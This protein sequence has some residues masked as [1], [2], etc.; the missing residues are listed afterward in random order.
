MGIYMTDLSYSNVFSQQQACMDYFAAIT[1]LATE[2][3]L[4]DVFTKDFIEK[5]DANLSNEDSILHYL[6]QS[7][8]SANLELKED[9]RESVA[10]L[11]AAGGWMEGL[12]IPTHII[13]P[14]NKNDPITERI[15]EQGATLKQLIKFLSSFK[16][17]KNLL[18]VISDLEELEQLFDKI[19]VES[20]RMETKNGDDGIAVVGKKKVYTFEGTLLKDIMEKAKVLR[21]KYV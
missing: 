16:D 6:S 15:A 3:S 14:E 8:W 20:V 10:G 9:D 5:V 13:H 18:D 7:Y 17:D 2:L 4:S 12:Y 21:N 1:E 11:I 19:T